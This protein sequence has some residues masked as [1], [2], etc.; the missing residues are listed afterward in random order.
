MK[1]G[2]FAR[3]QGVRLLS[4]EDVDSTNEEARR[5]IAAGERGPLWIVAARQ[6]KGRGRLGRDWISPP[7]NLFA[8]LQRRFSG[9]T[10]ADQNGQQFRKFQPCRTL[11]NQ[12]L[13]GAV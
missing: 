4:L 9:A 2:D 3:G 12:T 1:L 6:T 11:L 7:G 5:L 8:S 13:T 10:R